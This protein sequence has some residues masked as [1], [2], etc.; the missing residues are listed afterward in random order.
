MDALQSLQEEIGEKLC[1]LPREKLIELCSFLH[2]TS[3]KD[4][5]RLSLIKSISSHLLRSELEELE[6][7]G[8]AELLCI[9]EKISDLTVATTDNLGKWV[10]P[11]HVERDM[12]TAQRP[13]SEDSTVTESFQA[14]HINT[15]DAHTTSGAQ[16]TSD[17]RRTDHSQLPQ[18]HSAP[19]IWH[20]E[21][22]IS[23][24]IGEPGQKD[25]LSFSSLA[26]Q[27]ESGL[28]KGYPEQEI[29][30]AVI[31]SITPGLQLRSYLE[32][33][34][35][36][37][38][39]TLRRILRSHYQEKN[40]TELYKQLTTEGQRSKE[41][42]Q[43]FLIRALDLR[44]KILFASQEDESGLKYDPVLVQNM[45]L[46]SV[47]T[48]LQND[49]VQGDLQ[50]YLSDAAISDEVLLEK[51]NVACSRESERQ[52][53]RKTERQA[54]VHAT[55]L[56]EPVPEQKCQPKQSK[57]D[58]MSQLKRLSDDIMLI[59]EQIQQPLVASQQCFAVNNEEFAVK[60]AHHHPQNTTQISQLSPEWSP[61]PG[62]QAQ[63]SDSVTHEQQHYQFQSQHPQF[64][65]VSQQQYAPPQP[66][67]ALTHLA[68][69]QQP[70]HHHFQIPPQASQSPYPGTR[71]Y[72]NELLPQPQRQFQQP[73][74]QQARQ[75]FHCQQKGTTEL[76][77]HCY[78]CS[79]SEHYAAGC[80]V[81]GTR[82]SREIQ[83]N[84]QGS[85]Q[86]DRE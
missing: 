52:N 48:G 30:D 69:Q 8:M 74:R 10:E 80:R 24:L 5:T 66:R 33:K 44:Q 20:K 34:A 82:N 70:P 36:L 18:R 23:G 78:Y 2:I 72:P 40:A 83:L 65:A 14:M 81:R 9:H 68:Q 7:S 32:G 25:R 41:T 42:P 60:A 61:G 28:A 59:K 22:K 49:R 13:V 84:R 45:F 6:D 53:K 85:L 43:N 71:Q 63:R 37:T 1:T 86:R 56:D 51:L 47:L 67:H 16:A 35:G 76:C 54:I 73:R 3:V 50:P 26:R 12:N 77:T 38:L 79:S 15:A 62:H 21:F 57:F 4:V 27:I 55:Q 75:C 17:R 29:I 64:G 39:P 31:R 11:G 58:L 46:H 19:V